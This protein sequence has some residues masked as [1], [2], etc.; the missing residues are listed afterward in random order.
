[1]QIDLQKIKMSFVLHLV[2]CVQIAT[3][4]TTM[5]THSN[6]LLVLI[7]KGSI[8]VLWKVAAVQPPS[9]IK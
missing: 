7:G 1:M 9:K 6:S 5:Q 4:Q 3:M 2:H 8:L